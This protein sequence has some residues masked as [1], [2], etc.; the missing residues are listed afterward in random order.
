[1]HFFAE[2]QEI[3]AMMAEA[4]V[5]GEPMVSFWQALDTPDQF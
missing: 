2:S 5:E 1:V 4:G 3:G